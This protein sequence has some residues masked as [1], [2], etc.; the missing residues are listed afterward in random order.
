MVDISVNLCGLGLDNPIIPASGT[1]GFGYEFASIY[2][3]NILGSI[4][5]KGTTLNARYGNDLPRIAETSEGMLNCVGLQNP[6]ARDVV[7]NELVRL[8]EK[9]NKKIIANVSGF[10]I[11]E[12]VECSKILASSETVG[13][14]ELNVS[15]PNVKNGGMAFGIDPKMVYNVVSNVKKNINKPLVVKLSPN[16]EKI[17]EIS[18]SAESAGADGLC[19]VNTLLGM[20]IDTKN[21]R[22]VLSNT[23]GGLSG[24]AIFPIALRIVYQVYK[25][26]NIPIIACGGVNSVD[27]VIEMMEAGATAVEIGSENLVNPMICKEIIEDL[28]NYLNK[29]NI[30]NITDIIGAA[31]EKR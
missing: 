31:N 16:A 14:I 30:N 19:L 22:P 13:I 23:F 9:Y 29:I 24:P 21:K 6:G 12:Y 11:D 3:I 17:I 18:K 28:P 25:E 8:S 15:C 4:S 7:K 2:D 26:V 27:R 20:R 5:I 1:F 10:S